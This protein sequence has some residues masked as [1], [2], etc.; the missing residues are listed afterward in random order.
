MSFDPVAF[1]N[2][3]LSS[4]I[5]V[6]SGWLI[7][8]WYWKRSAPVERIL[9]ELKG[10]LPQYLH[11]LRFPQ[12][13]APTAHRIEFDVTRPPDLDVPRLVSVVLS[14]N[15]VAPG[16]AVELLL[17]FVD[18]GRNFENP[19]GLQIHDH[20]GRAVKAHFAWL[21]YATATFEATP[22]PGSDSGRITVRLR[23]TAGH[24]NVQTLDFGFGN[25]GGTS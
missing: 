17:N 18:R 24:E 16:A 20:C 15:P 23:D 2:L 9:K 22:L 1:V 14:R 8:H 12:F 21:G 13:H 6:A 3:L 11:P 19:A 25:P 5:G 10:A 7:A 4:L